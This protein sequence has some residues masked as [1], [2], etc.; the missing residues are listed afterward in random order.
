MPGYLPEGEP[1]EFESFEDARQYLAGEIE[2][3]ASIVDPDANDDHGRPVADLIA[4]RATDVREWQAPDD[5]YIEDDVGATYVYW[6]QEGVND[7][8]EPLPC[9]CIPHETHMSHFG[10]ALYCETEQN[11]YCNFECPHEEGE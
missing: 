4:L 7:T 6:I 11:P 10:T 8:R 1:A 3:H 2:H 5:T 9:G